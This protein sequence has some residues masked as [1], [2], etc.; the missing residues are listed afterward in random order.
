MIEGCL[1]WQKNGLIRPKAITEATKAYF[2][3]QDMMGEWLEEKCLV[4]RN[5]DNRKATT[6]ELFESWTRFAKANNDAIGT[7]R[8]F[9]QNLEKR[10]F[11]P[12][13]SVPTG[14]GTTRARGFSGIA[15]PIDPTTGRGA[16]DE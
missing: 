2:D 9:A 4:D 3:D 11:T 6:A 12:L 16:A 15:L 8:S 10:G 14:I 5:N 13:K 1:D 7:I